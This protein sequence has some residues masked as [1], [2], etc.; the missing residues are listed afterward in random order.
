MP[1]KI[2]FTYITGSFPSE[3]SVHQ[4][5]VSRIE[6][7]A[8]SVLTLFF[9]AGAHRPIQDLSITRMNATCVKLVVTMLMSAAMANKLFQFEISSL[10]ICTG[11]D[12]TL[13]CV[14]VTGLCEVDR[15]PIT[16]NE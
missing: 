16:T 1:T 13:F 14:S 10:V 15:E 5:L 7:E 6:W 3:N 2:V 9:C 8:F 4:T 11:M 12:S